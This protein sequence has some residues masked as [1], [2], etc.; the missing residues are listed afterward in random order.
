MP[1]WSSR[2]PAPPLPS[3]STRP[4]HLSPAPTGAY[5]ITASATGYQGIAQVNT[6]VNCSDASV[7]LRLTP[8]Q[9]QQPLPTLYR[10]FLPLVAKSLSGEAPTPT[11]TPTR[12]PLPTPPAPLLIGTY[13]LGRATHNLGLAKVGDRI[14]LANAL[15]NDVSVFSSGGAWLGK[16]IGVGIAPFGI[17]ANTVNGHLYVGNT[18]HQVGMHENPGVLGTISVLDSSTN[19][20][21]RFFST[22]VFP[23]WGAYDPGL[24]KAYFANHGSS[25]LL[26]IDGA[27]DQMQTIVTGIGSGPYGVAVDTTT[28]KVYVTVRDT[29]SVV[30]VDGATNSRLD[31]ER[32]TLPGEPYGIT[33]KPGSQI[34]VSYR[35]R[36]TDA[37]PDR[38]A[39]Y[40][41]GAGHAGLADV[42]LGTGANAEGQIV[43]SSSQNRVYI[44][45][46]GPS[47]STTN[48]D[49]AILDADTYAI[50][51][52]VTVAKGPFGI[53]ADPV[54]W[55][56][57]V[58]NRFSDS[59]SVIE[60]TQTMP[61]LS[62]TSWPKP[63][64][65]AP[66]TTPFPHRD[67]PR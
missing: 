13:P 63:P 44:P 33:V 12:T 35:N 51:A 59:F 5:T 45:E 28:H 39:I 20:Q 64:V 58:G 11:V 54:R 40:S 30:V 17:V 60:D 38:L 18:W 27:T 16:N 49:V 47:P 61:V 37:T 62:V 55:R 50:A 24:N 22:D 57:Y 1:S 56:I 7:L 31:A 9:E 43:Y 67:A 29:N 25:S 10:V 34:Y 6:L 8:N 19:V 21:T 26:V 46:G 48:G 53:I 15:T 42:Y 14:Y 66:V 65:A 36:T 41:A 52:R 32:I 2:V 23:V 3:P 4:L